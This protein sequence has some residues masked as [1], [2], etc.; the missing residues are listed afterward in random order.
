MRSR[1]RQREAAC[2]IPPYFCTTE[3]SDSEP[4]RESR[5]SAAGELSSSKVPAAGKI[6]GDLSSSSGPC[7]FCRRRVPRSFAFSL[8]VSLSRRVSNDRCHGWPAR[9]NRSPSGAGRL[10]RGCV[11]SSCRS[12]PP[13]HGV[14]GGEAE[15]WGREVEGNRHSLITGAHT[16]HPH[17]ALPPPT[18]HQRRTLQPHPRIDIRSSFK[19]KIAYGKL[20]ETIPTNLT[21]GPPPSPLFNWSPLSVRDV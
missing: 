12:S 7:S 11:V 6:R 5:A 3:G 16:F 1:P 17:P 21:D 9:Y 20:W 8:C 18:A 13:R 4:P 14:E 19:D 10:T 15:T 2:T